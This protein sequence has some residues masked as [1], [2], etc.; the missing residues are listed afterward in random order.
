MTTQ[1]WALKGGPDY[2]GSGSTVST[3]GTYSGVIVGD[4]EFD[5]STAGP[6]IPGDTL[7]SSTTTNT[8]ASNALGLFDLVVPTTGTASG[9]FLL[10]ADGTVFGGTIEGSADPNTDVLKGVVQGTYNFNIT[11]ISSSGTTTTT[12][13]TAQA[14][15]MIDAK[16]T[17]GGSTVAARLSGTANL[18]LSFGEYN[19][20]TLEPVIERIITFTVSGFQQSATATSSAAAIGTGTSGSASGSG[21]SGG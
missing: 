12:A 17:A 11:T 16:V 8:T 20:T 3:I 4:T 14:A 21:G 2:G 10:F 1:C 18:E 9:N 13:V 19:T 15:G 7:P 6:T 5:A